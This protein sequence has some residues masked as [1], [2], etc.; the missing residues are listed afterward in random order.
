MKIVAF[1]VE[2]GGVTGIIDNLDTLKKAVKATNAEF[3]KAEFGSDA[4]VKQEKALARLKNLQK[5]VRDEARKTGREQVIEADKGR[6]SYRALNAELV[7]LRARFKDLSEADRNSSVGTNLVKQ[8]SGLDGQLKKIDASI[9]LYQRNVGNYKQAL[10]GIGDVVTGGLL[11]G[12]IQAIG[13]KIVD[14]FQQ[15]LKIVSDFE[16]GLSTLSAITG[17]TGDDLDALGNK[18]IDLGV[19]YATSATEVVKAFQLIGSASPELLN[20]VDDLAAVTEQVQILG[21]AAGLELP[22]AAEAVTKSL[23]Q[24]GLAANQAASVAD[25]LATSQQRGTATIAQLS[26]SL[27]NVGSVA[28]ASNISFEQTNV[29]LQALAKGG[30]TGAEAGTKLRG[31]LL[32]LAK[33]GR[34]D[35]NPAL[36]SFE[37]I[38]GILEGEIEGV[39][40]AAA[41]FGE[42]NAAAALT[43]ISQVGVVSELTGELNKYG[44]AVDQA[45]INSDN[46]QSAT[47]KFAA[48][49]EALILSVNN[50]TGVFSK[51][52]RGI[53]DF[54]TDFLSA[55]KAINEGKFDNLFDAIDPVKRLSIEVD[56]LNERIRSSGNVLE[57]FQ[58]KLERNTKVI[59]ALRIENEKIG[60]SEKER[61]KNLLRIAAIEEKSVGLKENIQNLLLVEQAEKDALAKADENAAAAKDK[62]TEATKKNTE[63]KE[64]AAN[65]DSLQKLNAEQSKLSQQIKVGILDGVDY[66]NALVKWRENQERL[67]AVSEKFKE[68]QN[69]LNG[70]TIAGEQSV[71]FLSSAIKE[72]KSSLETADP[73]SVQGITNDLVEA[74]RQ[75]AAV[76]KEIDDARFNAQQGT[77]GESASDVS[78]EV[79]AIKASAE[80]QKSVAAEQIES[81]KE[82]QQTRV[83]IALQA[84]IDILE[85]RLKLWKEGTDEA[86]LLEA[87]LV[88]K[89]RELQS[90]NTGSTF[91]NRVDEIKRLAEIEIEANARSGADAEIVAAKRKEIEVRTATDILNAE[92][93]L[94]ETSKLRKAEIARELADI[95]IATEQEKNERLELIEQEKI[96]KRLALIDTIAGG[97]ND[98]TN[99]IS[100]IGDNAT[101]RAISNI[102]DRYSAEIEAAEGNADR[103]VAL[104][105][106]RDAEIEEVEREAFE[107]RKRL[108]IAQ[109]LIS[110]AQAV[111]ST[112]AAVPGP[113]DIAS[114]GIVRGLQIAF[115]VA[116]TAAQVAAIAGTTFAKGG[117]TGPG[118]GRKRDQTGQV[119]V[120]TVHADEY[121]VPKTVLFSKAGRALVDQLE[122]LR[123]GRPRTDVAAPSTASPQ[124]IP[125]FAP[126]DQFLSVNAAAIIED[127]EVENMARQI[128]QHAGDAIERASVAAQR[129]AAKME[130]RRKRLQNRIR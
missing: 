130:M 53:V 25:I 57:A 104:E 98:L 9:G 14:Q 41:I 65:S 77:T 42:E 114:L 71:K 13:T 34:D 81:S 39:T 16:K 27:K 52:A 99:S 92:L 127:D 48:A 19:K 82:L 90:T 3:E 88:E 119:P 21:K 66:T 125:N 60:I 23:N 8:I 35:L 115:A 69:S 4:Y 54:G 5:G 94:A 83:R 95:E 75:L 37:D 89:R 87:Q 33:T 73:G 118:K 64:K 45:A 18:A 70:E 28:R 67:N 76:K 97:I 79:E 55:F 105:E 100:A 20:N 44:A 40:D 17:L 91:D 49:Y 96:N 2:V 121:V 15:A 102:E 1:E 30:L 72:L 86:I 63:A 108:Q 56:E 128:G 109:A 12:G 80:L 124:V 50:G 116:T 111:L 93:A 26:E 107:R 103:I 120:G 43:L 38:L 22:V 123:T 6:N 36:N 68:I 32:R 113:V 7:N 59:E 74:E 126:R 84:D 112:L 10:I 31:I 122:G 62:E 29:L 101:D 85:S 47:D 129:E 58:L 110:G 24:F 106:Q 61:E 78:S 51:V 117:Y 11:T 46:L